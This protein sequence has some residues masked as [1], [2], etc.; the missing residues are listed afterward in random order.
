[1][2]YTIENVR[3]D[4]QVQKPVSENKN[5]TLKVRRPQ[6]LISRILKNKNVE[7]DFAYKIGNESSIF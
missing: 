3:K 7:L 5:R 4:I 2:I 6:K 1:M